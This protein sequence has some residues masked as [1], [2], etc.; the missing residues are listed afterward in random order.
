VVWLGRGADA[1][2]L[3]QTCS[4]RSSI[5]DGLGGDVAQVI[6]G[7]DPHKGSHTALALDQRED[8]IGQLRVV[9]VRVTAF[10]TTFTVLPNNGHRPL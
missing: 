7:L 5:R 6:I 3:N 8:N 1:I 2:D 9:A 4:P 10:A